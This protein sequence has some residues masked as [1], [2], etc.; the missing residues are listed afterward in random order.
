MGAALVGMTRRGAAPSPMRPG[1]M[2]RDAAP[3][4]GAGEAESVEPAGIVVGDARGKQRALPLD[5]RGLEAFELVQ[6]FEHAL[7]AG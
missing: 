4:D 5:G 2:R 1:G 3:A 6:R 7:F